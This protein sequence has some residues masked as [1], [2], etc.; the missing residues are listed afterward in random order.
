MT[1]SLGC[2]SY[3]RCEVRKRD[4]SCGTHPSGQ[5]VAGAAAR[6]RRARSE[7]LSR[8]GV[9]LSANR[10]ET[11]RFTTQLPIGTSNVHEHHANSTQTDPKTQL[12]EASPIPTGARKQVR[13]AEAGE[14]IETIGKSARTPPPQ[15][16]QAPPVIGA[17]DHL[18][19]HASAVRA[20]QPD[21]PTVLKDAPVDLAERNGSPR[22]RHE[23]YRGGSPDSEGGRY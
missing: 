13:A 7:R 22:R 15:T 18:T 4:A 8:D 3:S 9:K 6:R 10:P 17:G 2:V 11:G 16:R 1:I 23:L 19:C 21:A 12:A 14:M 20:G 5:D